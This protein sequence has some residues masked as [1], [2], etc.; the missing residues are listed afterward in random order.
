LVAGEVSRQIVQGVDV[1]QRLG[2]QPAH[3]APLR[4]ATRARQ[5]RDEA[6]SL[7]VTREAANRSTERP[8]RSRV[9]RGE[10][11]RVLLRAPSADARDRDREVNGRQA[12]TSRRRTWI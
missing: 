4:V 5:Q 3:R 11:A 10:E 7:L 1:R 9:G 8:R 6:P 12:T 2:R